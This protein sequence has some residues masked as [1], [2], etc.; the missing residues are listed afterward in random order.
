MGVS[1]PDWGW[2]LAAITIGI[3]LLAA[4]CLAAVGAVK[5]NVRDPSGL[6][7]CWQ[8][9]AARWSVPA[10]LILVP[11]LPAQ[12]VLLGRVQWL[13]VCS[14]PT[15]MAFAFGVLCQLA[16]LRKLLTRH[17][18]GALTFPIVVAR[19]LS[20]AVGLTL[21]GLVVMS[22]YHGLEYA[23]LVV[24]VIL[25]PLLLGAFVAWHTLLSYMGEWVSSERQFAIARWQRAEAEV[26]AKTPDRAGAA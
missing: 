23:S 16:Y 14:I 20:I 22:D 18:R 7:E 21:A 10:A 4:P 17:Q 2:G 6:N 1:I 11:A 13:L 24:F 15:A 9:R 5:L 3:S 19:V 8:R 26:Q 12:A 25:W